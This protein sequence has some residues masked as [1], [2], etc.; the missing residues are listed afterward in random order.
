MT[1]ISL[2][3]E[4]LIDKIV[5]KGINDPRIILNKNAAM[6]EA[7]K[8]LD[9]LKGFDANKA[10]FN[11]ELPPIVIVR[12]SKF[13]AYIVVLSPG[14]L[15]TGRESYRIITELIPYLEKI[16]ELGKKP[17]LIFYSKKGN[18]SKTA[19]LYLGNVIEN[20]GVGILFVNGAP[21][22]VVEIIWHLENTGSYSVEEEES[23]DY[24]Y[25][26]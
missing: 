26:K 19:Y 23:I 1:I 18:L 13:I 2:A 17:L 21:D 8:L 12:G 25:L 3:E 15:L 14:Y 11:N 5:K 22:E 16:K 20:H 4:T 10:D 9:Q 24:S 6:E 7:L